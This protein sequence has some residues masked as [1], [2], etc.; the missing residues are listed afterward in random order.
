AGALALL[1]SFAGVA[2]LGLNEW[3]QVL[4]WTTLA[5]VAA[6]FP[7]HIPR[8]KHSIAT[9]DVVIF[10]LLALHGAAAATVA[11][12]LEAFVASR[13]TSARVSSHWASTAAG[14]TAMAMGGALFEFSQAW[15]AAHGVAHA[16]AHMAALGAAALV[17]FSVS[18]MA[19]MQVICL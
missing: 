4:G 11:A 9:G 19:L 1:W 12:A 10:L 16:A 13:S 8:S 3:W 5:V 15:L 17:H 18:T 7:I 6:G 2:D 14:A